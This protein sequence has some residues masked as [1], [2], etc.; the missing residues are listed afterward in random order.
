MIVERSHDKV[1][2]AVNAAVQKAVGSVSA[3]RLRRSVEALAFPRHFTQE[4]DANRK[5][6][7]WIAEELRGL[8]YTVGLQGACDNVVARP[9][10]GRPAGTIL[11]GAHYDT[12][13]GSPGAD[14][15]TSAVAVCL[16]CAHVLHTVRPNPAMFVF[17]N[18]EE[19]GLVGSRDFVQN[20]VS[21]LRESVREAF[22]FE[23]VGFRS[24]RPGS[25]KSPPS[26]PIT[27]PDTGDF[28][29]LLIGGG[30]GTRGDTLLRLARTY[31]PHLP[32]LA[33]TVPPAL[34]ILYPD[35]LRSDH[36]PFWQAGLPAVMWTDT[37]E[38]RN[39]HYH[40]PSDTAKT[41]DF[42]FMAEIARLTGASVL[43]KRGGQT[44]P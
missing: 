41:L 11:L 16:E 28:L 21:S 12:V 42:D 18:R 23:M 6:R 3:A 39:P 13:P 44:N 1:P 32:T 15:N 40:K 30:A 25:Q 9:T 2:L 20:G 33:L 22:I 8:G 36:V 5:A 35:L 10:H 29:G 34:A 26:L 14:D 4:R 27:L 19:D 17:F 38:F 31:T 24:K 43:S 7:D 37:S